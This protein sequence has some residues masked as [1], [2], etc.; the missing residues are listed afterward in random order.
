MP[1]ST[2][3]GG[4]TLIMHIGENIKRYRNKLRLTQKELAKKVGMDDP[5]ISEIE[6]GKGNP[7][8][9]TLIAIA[10]ALET[11]VEKL[12]KQVRNS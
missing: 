8:L 5:R 4:E 6:H 3:S 1:M 7:T 12:V 10:D 9:S 11:S 2:V